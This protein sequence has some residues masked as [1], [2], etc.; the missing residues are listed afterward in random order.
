MWVISDSRQGVHH[1]VGCWTPARCSEPGVRRNGASM[2]I[3]Q[4][5]PV[6]SKIER[7]RA[8]IPREGKFGDH[9]FL[10]FGR[11]NSLL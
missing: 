8:A 7:S 9:A 4:A 5:R 6:C 10:T 11:N 3:L 2:G 1:S